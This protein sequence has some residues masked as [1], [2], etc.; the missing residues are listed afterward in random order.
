M[1]HRFPQVVA[2]WA[3]KK[4]LGRSLVVAKTKEPGVEDASGVE[5][6]RVPGRNQLLE[7]TELLVGDLSGGAIDNH[8]PAV[9]AALRWMLG[10][11]VGGEIEV[12]VR[13]A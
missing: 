12:V 1:H 6:E 3:Q 13:C 10:D 7:I 9:A 4:D 8:E 11:S 2:E 5:D